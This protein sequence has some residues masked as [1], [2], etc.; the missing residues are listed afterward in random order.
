MKDV[1]SVFY[2]RR[3]ENP[4]LRGSEALKSHENRSEIDAKNIK[5][6]LK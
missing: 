3:V 1:K 5:T 2:A 6:G 4:N